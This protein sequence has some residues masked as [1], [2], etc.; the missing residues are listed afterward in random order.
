MSDATGL[1]QIFSSILGAVSAGQAQDQQQKLTEQQRQDL[2]DALA[3][4]TGIQAPD[5]SFNLTAPEQ[6]ALQ[7]Y[8][9]P[10]SAQAQQVQIDPHDRANQ[11]AALQKLQGYS[12]GAADS[13][14]NAANYNAMNN[15]SLGRQRADA[16]T[17]QNLASRGVAGSGLEIA[18]KM[19]AS[20]NA[21][22][23]AQAG[24]LQ[25]AHGLALAKLQGNNDYLKGLS[26]LRGQDTDLATANANIINQFNMA[27]TSE[28][29]RVNQANVG[30]T[31]Q[32]NT[33]NTSQGNA[34]QKYLA[35]M[36]QKAAQQEYD[37]KLTQ[38]R[39]GAGQQT[40]NAEQNYGAGMTG[41]ALGQNTIGQ[42]GNA[43]GGAAQG[44]YQSVGSHGGG[45]EFNA[46]NSLGKTSDGRD[47]Q[48]KPDEM[49]DEEGS[50]FTGA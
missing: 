19:Q 44:I 1:G 24:G 33:M 40:T 41:V 31:N 37:N 3:K 12:N 30:L 27:N 25:A 2:K 15:A 47:V 14:L 10:E 7:H 39:A 4:I 5:G 45:D 18:A 21:A 42:I 17:M 43:V 6:Y 28:R 38:A 11:M 49:T 46:F 23:Q 35:E 50:S 48:Q 32:Q 13:E 29:N 36:K 34:Y 8:A 26:G 9:S 16:A 22:N 20:Q